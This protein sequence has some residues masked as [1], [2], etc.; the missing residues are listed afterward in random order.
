[1]RIIRSD[2]STEFK[3]TLFQYDRKYTLKFE[4]DLKVQEYKV[5]ENSSRD[6]PD[7]LMELALSDKIQE[8]VKAL[9]KNMEEVRSNFNKESQPDEVVFPNII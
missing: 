1:M 9:F 6:Q 7:S 5:R 8:E 4:K 2:E 3:I